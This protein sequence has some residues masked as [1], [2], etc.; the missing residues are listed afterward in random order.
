MA[1]TTETKIT[2]TA[3]SEDI[4]FGGVA[5]GYTGSEMHIKQ[6]AVATTNNTATTI[7]EISLAEGEA[8]T[9]FATI[10]A[11]EDDFSQAIGGHVEATF[12]RASAGNVT[13][14]GSVDSNLQ[15]DSGGSPTATLDADT[16]AQTARI[17]V[18][19][20]TAV[21]YDWVVT[22]QYHKVLTSS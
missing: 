9:I 17:R 7:A 1:K 18:T 12:R 8:V 20:E 14:V 10:L 21:N 15:N 4:K 22:Y 16:T 19:G 5:N 13:L 6:A 2:A 11:V 3:G